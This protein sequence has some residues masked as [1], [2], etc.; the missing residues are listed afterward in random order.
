MHTY[1]NLRRQ[2]SVH[3][4]IHCILSESLSREHMQESCNPLQ[5]VRGMYTCYALEIISGTYA[6]FLQS[7]CKGIACIEAGILHPYSNAI[8]ELQVLIIAS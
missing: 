3:S 4:H 5:A 2:I 7:L 8:K 6:R 1:I